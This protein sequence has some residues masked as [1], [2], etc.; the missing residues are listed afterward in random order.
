VISEGE[1]PPRHAHWH[2]GGLHDAADNGAIG[3]C[4]LALAL[5]SPIFEER[6]CSFKHG[7]C[8]GE[9]DFFDLRAAIKPVMDAPD[10]HEVTS[11][12]AGHCA[13]M[14]SSAT[15]S[16]L[17]DQLRQ[18]LSGIEHTCFYSCG[19][20]VE[21]LCYFVNQLL[22]VIDQVDDLTMLRR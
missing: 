22:V 3:E 21:N 17:L 15:C 9:F 13:G 4:F 6:L 16:A 7:P 11:R 2:C 20:H 18:F 10:C 19:W 8:D 14:S 12:R 5:I 1:R